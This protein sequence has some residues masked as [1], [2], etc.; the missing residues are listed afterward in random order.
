MTG[1]G[2]CWDACVRSLSLEAERPMYPDD[3]RVE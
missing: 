2:A 1:H 3:T